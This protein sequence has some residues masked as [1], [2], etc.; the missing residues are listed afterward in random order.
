MRGCSSDI[1]GGGLSVR[2]VCTGTLG[3]VFVPIL[4]LGEVWVW[5][6]LEAVRL[7]FI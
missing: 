4:K 7:H 6:G 1:L 3:R 5:L 2:C